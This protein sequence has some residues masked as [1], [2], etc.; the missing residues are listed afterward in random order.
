MISINFPI[1]SIGAY[2][3]LNYV[4]MTITRQLTNKQH[5]EPSRHRN[6]GVIMSL[7]CTQCGARWLD[8]ERHRKVMQKHM[9]RHFR[10]NNKLSGAL[11]AQSRNWLTMEEVR[12]VCRQLALS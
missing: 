1:V 4:K 10:I 9:D 11:R 3:L 5:P 12:P 2:A 6:V 7:Q 8:N